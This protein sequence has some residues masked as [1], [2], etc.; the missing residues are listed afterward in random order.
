[1]TEKTYEESCMDQLADLFGF[2]GHQYGYA[3]LDVIKAI[4][5]GNT[6]IERWICRWLAACADDDVVNI[7]R[8]WSD[9]VTW[10]DWHAR[11]PVGYQVNA[12]LSIGDER[13]ARQ[14]LHDRGVLTKDM[15]S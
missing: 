10:A 8:A 1:M 15:F 4:S 5:V 14:R 3:E 13:I 7:A 12:V 9:V 2:Q 6:T 11:D